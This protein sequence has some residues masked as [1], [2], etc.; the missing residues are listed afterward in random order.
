M[1]CNETPTVDCAFLEL[2][3]VNNYATI[4]NSECDLQSAIFAQFNGDDDN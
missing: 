4:S 2:R 3:Q 1:N